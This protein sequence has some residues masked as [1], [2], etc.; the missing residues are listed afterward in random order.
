MDALIKKATKIINKYEHHVAHNY[1]DKKDLIKIDQEL[2]HMLL[3]MIL[4][5]QKKVLV[6]KYLIKKTFDL[7]DSDIVFIRQNEIF[8]K[9][10]NPKSANIAKCDEGTINCRYN[11]IDESELESFY[12]NFFIKDIDS[13]F[14]YTCAKE[15]VNTYLLGKKIDNA[16]YEKYVFSLIQTIIKDKLSLQFDH[17]EE[18]F[19][20]FSGYIFRIHFKEVFEHIAEL[21]LHE[22]STS[23]RFIMDFLKYY[24]LNVISQ[25]GIKYKVPE[26]EAQSGH[27]W[28]VTSMMSIVKIY[29]KAILNIK[30]LTKE[31]EPLKEQLQKQNINNISPIEHNNEIK[32]S[33]EEIYFEHQYLARKQSAYIASHT[34]SKNKSEKERLAKEIKNIKDMIHELSLKKEQLQERL[35]LPIRLKE[36]NELKKSIDSLEREISRD[37]RT[38]TLN[39]DAFLSI[40]Y[41]L[42]KALTSKKSAIKSDF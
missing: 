20:G 11:G 7:L 23:N 10:F 6:A 17:S 40:K 35:I 24:S 18:F 41:S 30:N 29:I 39:K 33:I 1:N 26:L 38:I 37:E 16:A 2:A 27:K 9:L 15:F 3:D 14:F 21:I 36:Y 12:N 28:S 5:D 13:G 25:N 22:L 4:D 31:M 19:K 8:I 34:Q 42:I 32:K